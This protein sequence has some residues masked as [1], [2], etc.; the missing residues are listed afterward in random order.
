MRRR[1]LFT[2]EHQPSDGAARGPHHRH[3]HGSD[4]QTEAARQDRLEPIPA[5][6]QEIVHAASP[7]WSGRSTTRPA[8]AGWTLRGRGPSRAARSR[9][10]I[11]AANGS[12]RLDANLLRQKRPRNGAWCRIRRIQPHGILL[13]RHDKVGLRIGGRLLNHDE[14]A[15]REPVMVTEDDLA[16]DVPAFGPQRGKETLGAGDTGD[17]HNTP[18]AIG[19]CAMWPQEPRSVI[20][21]NHA[22]HRCDSQPGADGVGVSLGTGDQQ[23]IRCRGGLERLAQ[24]SPRQEPLLQVDFGYHQ[25]VNVARQWHMLKPVVQQMHGA[26]ERPFGKTSRQMPIGRDQHRDTRQ[27]SRQHLGLVA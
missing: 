20:T 14:I 27:R 24:P 4:D 3:G 10:L 17:R 6:D 18:A 22:K 1:G 15:L 21:R 26:P 12:G 7:P 8:S 13:G 16:R 19:R 9:S 25:Q 2:N 11:Q 23:G 5:L